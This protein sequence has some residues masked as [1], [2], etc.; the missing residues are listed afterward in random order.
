MFGENKHGWNPGEPKAVFINAGNRKPNEQFKRSLCEISVLIVISLSTAPWHTETK[1][2]LQLSSDQ[3]L[4]QTPVKQIHRPQTLEAGLPCPLDPLLTPAACDSF[5][6]LSPFNGKRRAARPCESHCLPHSPLFACRKSPEENV[7]YVPKGQNFKY[8]NHSTGHHGEENQSCSFS[9]DWN[10]EQRA[11]V[12]FTEEF[13]HMLLGLWDSIPRQFY[14]DLR[15]SKYLIFETFGFQNPKVSPNCTFR[16]IWKV[17]S[18][19]IQSFMLLQWKQ[20]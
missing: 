11:S 8:F 2:V 3:S 1:N 7:Q 12:S 14:L 4:C 15:P 20:T 17:S 19:L 9:K 5:S 10:V 6:A 16:S 13:V 18:Q